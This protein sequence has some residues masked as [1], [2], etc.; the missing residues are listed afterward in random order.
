MNYDCMCYHH[1][2]GFLYKLNRINN[3]ISEPDY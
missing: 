2:N 3:I 1:D